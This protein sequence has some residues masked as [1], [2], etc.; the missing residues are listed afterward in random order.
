[1][2]RTY[3]TIKWILNNHIK[4]T[5]EKDNFTCIFENYDGDSRIYT[6]HQLIKLLDN[7]TERE[8]N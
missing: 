8:I 7:D 3:K 4:K 1:M 2:K 5:W 6:P